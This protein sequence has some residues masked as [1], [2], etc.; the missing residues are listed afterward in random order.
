MRRI[1]APVVAALLVVTALAWWQ[2]GRSPADAT[3]PS[4]AG[5]SAGPSTGSA[6][7]AATSR[8]GA[9]TVL[10]VQSPSQRAAASSVAAPPTADPALSAAAAAPSTSES[11]DCLRPRSTAEASA[12]EAEATQALGRYEAASRDYRD[13]LGPEERGRYD[14]AESAQQLFVLAQ[15]HFESQLAAATAPDTTPYRNSRCVLRE[16]RQRTG[17]LAGL[18]TALQGDA[19]V[20]RE[21][22]GESGAEVAAAEASMERAVAAFGERLGNQSPAAAGELPFTTRFGEVQAQWGRY[23]AAECDARAAVIAAQ[24]GTAG[25][26]RERCLA[27]LARQRSVDI[28]GLARSLAA[29]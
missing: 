26:A 13:R 11:R 16:F 9:P 10:P 20:P 24:F 19:G 28:E 14:A 2:R 3:G 15:C 27:E 6:R 7:P 12:C 8:S 25:D 1:V 18:G 23:R 29:P 17:E 4:A 21:S 22:T 5:A